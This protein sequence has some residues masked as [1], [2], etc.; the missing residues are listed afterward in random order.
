MPPSDRS[1]RIQA[2]HSFVTTLEILGLLA[3]ALYLLGSIVYF[4]KLEKID[5]NPVTWLM[6]S[7]GTLIIIVL[8]W[9]RDATWPEL[10]LPIVDATLDLLI[11]FE[12]WRRARRDERAREG[13]ARLWPGKL[14]PQNR[15]ERVS[16]YSDLTIT[17]LY[18]GAWTLSLVSLLP[19][20]SRQLAVA[21]FLAFSN[22]TVVTEFSPIVA[23]TWRRPDREHWM[24]WILWTVGSGTLG[25]VTYMNHG[26]ADPLMLYPMLSLVFC[27][28][29]G[30]LATGW[31]R[32]DLFPEDHGTTE[33]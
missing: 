10:V 29:V 33:H 30:L 8:E 18:V 23:S 3:G 13:V 7:Y 11:M 26:W 9:D 31:H 21:F 5:P 1:R 28:L 12:V 27:C 22:L 17:A 16:L 4:S 19:E 24:P 20:E 14:R 32:S 15:L 2:T 25:Y 6:F